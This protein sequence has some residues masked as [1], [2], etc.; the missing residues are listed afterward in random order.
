MLD[1]LD[2]AELR[3]IDVNTLATIRREIATRNKDAV[4]KHMM[5]ELH[6]LGTAAD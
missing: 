5:E 1:I 2:I 6:L 3:D 4:L